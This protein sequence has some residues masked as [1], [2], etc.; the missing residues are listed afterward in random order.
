MQSRSPALLVEETGYETVQVSKATIQ[1]PQ[2]MLKAPQP[3][4]IRFVLLSHT[5]AE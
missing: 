5:M 2:L 1:E 4:T 3:R